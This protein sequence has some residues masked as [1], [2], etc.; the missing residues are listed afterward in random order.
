MVLD[1]RAVGTAEDE[2]SRLS[3]GYQQIEGIYHF[4]P[5]KY[6]MPASQQAEQVY[7]TYR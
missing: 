4:V 7:K 5:L 3:A 6:P 1:L 2:R